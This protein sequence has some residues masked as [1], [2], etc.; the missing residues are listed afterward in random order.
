VEPGDVLRIEWRARP[1]AAAFVDAL[2]AHAVTVE[3]KVTT[4]SD[5]RHPD[6][7]QIEELARRG[8]VI[9]LIRVLRQDANMRLE[10]A[11]AEAERLIKERARES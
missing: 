7:A 8:N 11:K 3:S 4:R 2:A 6:A 9:D 10:D 1:S 5:L